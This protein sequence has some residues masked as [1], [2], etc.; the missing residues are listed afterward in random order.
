[1]EFIKSGKYTF[2]IK[3]S[4]FNDRD[5]DI[6]FKT[7]KMGGTYPDDC[8]NIVIVYKNNIPTT[9][10]MPHIMYDEECVI[11]ENPK[12]KILL[13]KGDGSKI[14]IQTMLGYIKQKYP[15]IK[16]VEYDDMSSIECATEDEIINAK[17]QK[18]GTNMK[19]LSLYY[20]S[21][22]YNGQTW[23]EKYF[24][25]RM[26][27][28]QKHIKYRERVDN[29]LKTK[30]MDFKEF[31]R[32]ILV[33]N[34]LLGE[35]YEYYESA[36][37]YGDF[38][39]AIPKLERCRLLRP[40]IDKFMEYYLKNIFFNKNWVIPLVARGGSRKTRKNHKSFYTPNNIRLNTNYTGDLGITI[41]DV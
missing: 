4:T 5:G 10:K 27:D 28:P 34:N 29:L 1:M 31:S 6:M 13:Q 19:P 37:T 9:A 38:F 32:I 16:E 15:S 22:V 17:N 3:E 12:E 24:N 21:I 8:V 33:P 2:A 30:P 35:L 11:N 25:A 14:M 40:W 41:N 26:Q 7:I 18:R 20:L 36:E 39:Q 23:Y